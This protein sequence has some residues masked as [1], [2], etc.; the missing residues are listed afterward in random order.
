MAYKKNKKVN[1]DQ[2]VAD[3]GNWLEDSKN[4]VGAWQTKQDK[5][6]K[7]RMRIKSP[8]S[9]PFSGCANIRMPTIET[10]I[11]KLKAAL[12]NVLFGIRPIVQVVPTPTGNWETALKIEM[13]L[14]HLLMNVMKIK[15]NIIIAIDQS[16]E[17]GFFL[18]KPF[19]KVDI[20]T[21]VE[22][23]KLDDLSVQEAE[24]L[25]DPSRTPEEV[26]QAIVARFDVDMSER[27]AEDNQAVLTDAVK[28]ILSGEDAV[29]IQ[30]KDVLCDYPELA[31]CSPER[32]YV[33][34]TTGYDVQ[35]A[36]YIIH[37]F[38]LPLR[39]V[40]ANAK[41]K[42]WNTISTSEI[43]EMKKVDLQ[44][45]T[46]DIT[47][48]KR[49]GIERLQS[50]EELVKIHECYCWYDI[51]GDG[52]EEKCVITIA[53]DFGKVLRKI[54]I[55][56]YSGKFPFVKFFYELTDDRWFSH[57]GIPEIIEDIVKEIDM[58]HMQKLDY[59]TMMN[60]PMFVYRAGM[61][62]TN[63]Q[64]F[65]FGQG[66]AV[67]GMSPL[68][69]TFAPLNKQNPNVEF[70]YEREQMLLE[71]KIEEL[72]G[73]VDFTLQSMINKRQPRTLGEVQMQ[74]QN[75][76]QV[77]S[78]DADLFRGQFEELINWVYEL[79]CQYGSDEYEFMYF[80][81][82]MQKGLKIKLTKEELQG[83][84]R[85]TIRGNDQNTNPQV[86]LQKAQ[87]ILLAA[88]NPLML[89]TGVMTPPNVFNAMKRFYQ[90]LD[91]PNWEELLTMP[92]P[93][94]PPAPVVKMGLSDLTDAEASQVLAKQGI[95]PDVQGR[96]LKSQAIIHEK[97][98]QQRKDNLE[99]L[100]MASEM[101]EAGNSEGEDNM[102]SSGY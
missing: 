14:D 39:D 59:G 36:K 37:E 27:V 76:Q 30:V 94:A 101:M 41:I 9:F 3:I 87:Q 11:R 85:I 99:A 52:E 66:L 49:E 63:A 75:M 89:Q 8:K 44:D 21:R 7:L 13:F 100:Q 54:T 51:N 17:K 10:K 71:A 24:W 79:W 62:N 4:W 22:E 34:T 56:F 60:S 91:I 55:P 29:K 19:W 95:Q 77:F 18:V 6:H 38:F 20:I 31:L 84:Y 53:P 42:G 26:Q 67:H 64:Q 78:L 2:I 12:V 65:L 45:Q 46:T 82:E 68:S 61:V 1:N 88:Q 97:S 32:V 15:N 72:I 40:K 98:A 43:E 92:Q 73:Q 74:N 5:W 35:N 69:D 58:Q 70:S 16:L 57:R 28:K 86:R 50:E 96:A 48:D 90:E 80:G 25:F 81:Q 83:K 23:L 47:K 102:E 93:P 33:P